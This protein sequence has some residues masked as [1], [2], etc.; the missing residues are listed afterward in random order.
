MN[1]AIIVAAGIGTRF[2]SKIPKQFLDIGGKPLLIHTLEKFQNCAA[3][4]EI[5]LILSAD[6]TENF[7]QTLKKFNIGK[8]KQTIA[9][10]VTRAESVLNGL[11]AIDS[12]NFEIGAVHDGARPLVS[13]EEIAATIEKAK[14]FDAACLT[15]TVTD[16]IKRVANGKIVGTIDRENLRRALTPQAFRF[17][18]L[19]KAFAPENFDAAA[20][21]ECFLVEKLGCE[22]AFVD[23]SAKNIK[24]TTRE[25]FAV[26]ESLLKEIEN[27]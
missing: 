23:G 9:G 5:I 17:E 20:T 11:N 12:E 10:G 19:Q 13:G 2:S 1:F 6:E 24:I 26:A 18:I 22:I 14:E 4:D 16:T 8:L 27:V 15:A 25:D 3:I 21:D 7:T